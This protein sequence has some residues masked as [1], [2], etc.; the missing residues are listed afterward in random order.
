MLYCFNAI[1]G[2]PHALPLEVEPTTPPA[3]NRPPHSL[4]TLSTTS[5]GTSLPAAKARSARLSA[6]RTR[7]A[8]LAASA[9]SLAAASAAAA[10]AR[11]LSAAC[12]ARLF[13]SASALSRR[14]LASFARLT[15]SCAARRPAAAAAA[16]SAAGIPAAAAAPL[17]DTRLA[18]AVVAGTCRSRFTGRENE[19]VAVPVPVVEEAGNLA[20]TLP[21]A[22][23]VEATG[24]EPPVCAG[25]GAGVG[26]AK[27]NLEV[28]DGAAEPP[29]AVFALVLP[30]QAPVADPGV[31]K[32]PLPRPSFAV[33]VAS[34]DEDDAGWN[35]GAPEEETPPKKGP[36][37]PALGL[38]TSAGS[39]GVDA[40]P[41]VA[42]DGGA[43]GADTAEEVGAGCVAL[44]ISWPDETLPRVV[45]GFSAA[46]FEPPNGGNPLDGTF[47]KPTPGAIP[48]AP[49]TD[50]A[51]GSVD[52]PAGDEKAAG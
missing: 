48:P 25:V 39:R 11:C 19:S 37:T 21:A 16:V 3:S 35:V 30:P 2:N 12:S 1:N 26:A 47:P 10:A 51:P 41:A 49:G 44:I 32:P 8:S 34:R 28:T 15:S 40:G 14:C 17:P 22:A 7:F 18:G 33:A 36:C 50:P 9:A 52:A 4:P 23:P 5:S 29:G 46:D 38:E 27:V 42:G 13:S 45:D 31:A 6:S 24:V 20:S 43:A